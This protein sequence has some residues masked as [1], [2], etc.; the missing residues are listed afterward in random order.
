MIHPGKN[1]VD[2][3]VVFLK[4][5]AHLLYY[6]CGLSLRNPGHKHVK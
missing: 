3:Q 2:A 5:L 6:D 4:G 1:V